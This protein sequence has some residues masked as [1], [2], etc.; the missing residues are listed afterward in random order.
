MLCWLHCGA[1]LG[2]KSLLKEES[3]LE[4]LFQLLLRGVPHR[5]GAIRV[6][7]LHNTRFLASFLA[8]LATEKA[9]LRS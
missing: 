2:A 1:A 5:A 9:F 8:L 7:D 4:L 6:E 3:G